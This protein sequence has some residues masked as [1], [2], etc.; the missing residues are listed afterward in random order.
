M[1]YFVQLMAS[2][3]WFMDSLKAHNCYQM[4]IPWIGASLFLSL[5]SYCSMT[6]HSQVW[7][8]VSLGLLS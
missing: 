3:R 7:N 8:I 2:W 6:P 4:T 5:K 1:T